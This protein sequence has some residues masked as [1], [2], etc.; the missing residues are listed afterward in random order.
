MEIAITALILIFL[1]PIIAILVAPYKHH[2]AAKEREK[3][4]QLYE[5]LA[6]EKLDV[7]KTAITMGFEQDDIKDLDRRLEQLV[8]AE[9]LSSLLETTPDVP[10]ARQDREF[11]D[12]DLD[13]EIE[14]LTKKR[15][16]QDS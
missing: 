4:R 8:G 13:S 15:L 16:K 12:V 1:I 6:M 10:A 2:L 11:L 14:R 7:I 3:A 9:K 5:R